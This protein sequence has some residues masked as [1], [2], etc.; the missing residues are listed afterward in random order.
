MVDENK[1]ILKLR[2]EMN[3]IIKKTEI[4]VFMEASAG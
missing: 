1:A 4:L 2:T 3:K